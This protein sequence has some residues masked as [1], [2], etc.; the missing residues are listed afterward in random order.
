MD[1]YVLF[2]VAASGV[3]PR[4][5]FGARQPAR[6][7]TDRRQL[8]DGITTASRYWEG[9]VEE[10][11]NGRT[12]ADGAYFGVDVSAIVERLVGQ[13]LE[14][15]GWNCERANGSVRSSFDSTINVLEG[16]LE[17]EKPPA[18]RLS[19]ER[20]G[21]PVRSICWRAACSAASARANRRTSGSCG[22]RASEP[23][24]L[25]RH[26]CA[27]LFPSASDADRGA[28]RSAARR[29]DRATSASKRRAGRPL[30]AGLEP[31]MGGRGS[32]STTE[33]AS[34]RDG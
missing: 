23:L 1:G 15:G 17:F 13:R 6:R 7:R 21:S 32:R 31:A 20:R 4:S 29:G 22:I 5:R 3:R 10:C 33:R 28:A 30:A 25:R 18:A 27:R 11:I 16:L 34:P 12:V 26:A 9:E 14:D 19:R 24:A 2:A 8:R